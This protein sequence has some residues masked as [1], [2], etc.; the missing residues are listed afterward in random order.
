[1][2]GGSFPSLESCRSPR[3][4]RTHAAQNVLERA[5][6]FHFLLASLGGLCAAFGQRP[7]RC[8]SAR[9]Q[10]GGFALRF[11]KQQLEM[12]T[13][14][15]PKCTPHLLVLKRSERRPTVTNQNPCPLISS[16]LQ[17]ISLPFPS[18]SRPFPSLYLQTRLHLLWAGTVQP[19]PPKW[20]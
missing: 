20:I 3:R 14:P 11:P 13:L 18:K 6:T 9:H 12:Y 19:A 2:D 16:Q 5:S 10:P 1:M 7:F 17:G 4:M 8:F 15:P